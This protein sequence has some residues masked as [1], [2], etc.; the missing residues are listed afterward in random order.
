MNS[1]IYFA[2]LSKKKKISGI[3]T[4]ENEDLTIGNINLNE[5]LQELSVAKADDWSQNTECLDI[6]LN[7]DC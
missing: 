1:L 3:N 2:L 4:Y 7:T 5:W 6:T